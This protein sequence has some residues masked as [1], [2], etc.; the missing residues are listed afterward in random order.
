MDVFISVDLE[1]ITGTVSFSQCDHPDGKSEYPYARRMMTHDVNAAIRGA[2]LAGAKR[3]VVKD[4]HWTCKNLLIDEL[5][6]G[7]E[8]ISGFGGEKDGM[9]D[10]VDS[11]FGAAMLVGYH[12]MP[13]GSPGVMDHALVGGLHRF[14]VNGEAWGEIATSAAVAAE[15]GVPLVAVSSDE[16]GC[17]EARRMVPFVETFATKQ[18]MAHSAARCLHPSVT[19]PGIEAASK[20]GVEGASRIK[21]ARCPG[22]VTMRAE[23]VTTDEADPGTI[24][25]GVTRVDGYTLEWTRPDFLSAH[26]LMQVV[27]RLSMVGRKAD[28]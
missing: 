8:L 4:A 2:R 3:I 10:G 7:I 25:E 1:G 27:F 16:S 19:G 5:E 18:G 24:V 26:R 15:Y 12:V 21:P 14:L 28:D 6:T 23:F 20:R 22:P 9:M 11:S 17:E 13:G